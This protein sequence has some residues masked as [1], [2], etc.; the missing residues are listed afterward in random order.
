MPQISVVT[1]S[2]N[3]GCYLE[4]TLNSV[5]CQRADV[6]LQYIV[7]DGASTDDS[8]DILR[9]NADSIDELIMEADDGQ[10]HA[11][12]KG[13]ECASGDILAYLNSDDTYLPGALAWVVE[14]FAQNPK[15]DVLYGHRIFVDAAGRMQRFWVLPPHSNY[16]MRR[17]AYI[18][19][20]TCFWRRSVTDK[21]GGIDAS[22]QFAMDYELFARVMPHVQFKR[23]NKF[24]ATFREHGASKTSRLNYTLGIS[25]VAR[26]HE[27]QEIVIGP[28]DHQ[29]ARILNISIR[30]VSALVR[31]WL[32]GENRYQRFSP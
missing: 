19:Q 9:R 7:G 32:I 14:Y 29:I 5:I 13:F 25:E 24:L 3:Q 20:E 11:L 8:Q 22:F 16:L 2:F 26:I 4:E 17:W 12:S 15:V 30:G 18:P 10:A 21:Y 27:E 1:P 6:D 31:G 28:L 23:V